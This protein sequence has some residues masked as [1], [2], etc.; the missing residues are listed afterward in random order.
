MI[1]EGFREWLRPLLKDKKGVGLLVKSA[2]TKA[3][4]ALNMSKPSLYYSTFASSLALWRQGVLG[5]Q[6]VQDNT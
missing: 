2:L 6:G 4:L 3:A 5:V 1:G